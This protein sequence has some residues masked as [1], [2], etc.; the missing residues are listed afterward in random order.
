MAFLLKAH[1]LLSEELEEFIIQD[2]EHLNN[3]LPTCAQPVTEVVMFILRL[4]SYIV[5]VN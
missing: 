2:L 1:G 3:S 5:Y 4:W